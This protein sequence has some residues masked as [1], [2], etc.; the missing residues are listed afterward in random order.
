[1]LAL[2]LFV[3]LGVAAT[4]DRSG[5]AGVG[6]AAAG[7]A[8]GGGNGGA[9][10]AAGA[11]GAGGGGGNGGGAGAAGPPRSHGGV[12]H[13]PGAAPPNGACAVAPTLPDPSLFSRPND[14][15]KAISAATRDFIEH[16]DCSTR[17]CIADA[18]DQYAAALSALSPRLPKA[19]R[20]LPTVVSRAAHRVRAA[21]TKSEAV[22]I[23]KAAIAEVHKQIE[24]VRAE[25]P[26]ASRSETR[27]A[28]FVA[29]TLNT[30]AIALERSNAL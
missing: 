4:P 11:A 29:G 22:D 14:A 18:L 7:T 21:R 30:A 19:L 10:G 3:I 12:P 15:V 26:D 25:N 27:A 2:A 20:G 1:M 5:A 13:I 24:L 16:C 9:A 6:A 28:D 8:G 23:V 17:T